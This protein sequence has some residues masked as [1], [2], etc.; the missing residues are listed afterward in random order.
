MA[1]TGYRR[2][3]YSRIIGILKIVLP[4]TA[5]VLLSLVFLLARTIDPTQAI[6]TAAIDVEDRARDPRLSSA[7]FAG[8]TEDGAAL[9]IVT[10]TARS[11]SSTALRLEVT[12][13]HLDLEGQNGE[14][15][16]ASA[17]VGLLDRASGR[18]EM[19]GGLTIDVTPGY[20]LTSDQL[21]GLL[22]A[23]QIEAP[24]TITGSAPAGEITAGNMTMRAN[25]GEGTGYMLVFGGGVRLIY[26]PEN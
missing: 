12:G 1:D 11:E 24:G 14:T 6:R 10:E 15:L 4:L 8:V 22:D 18:F 20:R 17:A 19:T 21:V 2:M 7:R 25:T 26:Q 5:L 23:T 9:T 3:G 16:S 13:L